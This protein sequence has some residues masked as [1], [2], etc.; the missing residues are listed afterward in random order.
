MNP[1]TFE[2]GDESYHACEEDQKMREPIACKNYMS[3]TKLREKRQGLGE[4]WN[5]MKTIQATR[6]KERTGQ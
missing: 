4:S 1:E 6:K 2:C 5:T 3:P